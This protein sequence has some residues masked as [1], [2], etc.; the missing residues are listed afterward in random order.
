MS[1][2]PTPI[3]SICR[4]NGTET[5]DSS[6]QIGFP[7]LPEANSRTHFSLIRQWLMDCDQ[8]HA[9]HTTTLRPMPKRVIDVEKG[10]PETVHLYETNGEDQRYVA[11]SHRWGPREN[12]PLFCTYSTNIADFKKTGI[13]VKDLPKTF[14]D[15]VITTRE[16]GIR[17]LWIDSLCIIQGD[18]GDWG[19]Q[20]RCM[21]EVFSSAYCVIAGSRATGTT[22]GFL[23]E[24]LQRKCAMFLRDLDPPIY[25]CDAIDNF[26]LHVIKGALNKRGWVLQERALARRT[27]Y[28]TEKQ[29]YWEC[30]HGVRCETLTK[31]RNTKAS[32]LGD[33]EF[34]KLAIEMSKG[35]K[36]R[37]YETLYK[38]YSRLELTKD[39]D[40]P[41]AIAGLEKRI[42]NALG[43]RGGYGVFEDQEAGSGSYLGRSLLWKRSADVLSMVRITFNPNRVYP[44]PSWSWMA[45]QGAI[46]Y[47]D[48]PFD[49]VDWEKE[50]IRSPWTYIPR[51]SMWLTAD[52]TANTMLT[53]VGRDLSI[54][55][56]DDVVFDEY[57]RKRDLDLKCVV[58]GCSKTGSSID[59]KIHYVLLVGRGSSVENGI[60]ERLGVAKL[61][62]KRITLDGPGVEL[63]IQ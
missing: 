48:L 18:N 49:G 37:L 29:T 33:P 41:L 21:E 13:K 8:N 15:S 61:P 34:P 32:F 28:F 51:K 24:R 35:G 6:I 58:I 53:G 50:E 42:I 2:D 1:G 56:E 30:G 14:E 46:D 11:L 12:H 27:V 10:W 25:V 45:Y 44:V 39:E 31:M 22:D 62:G 5:V 17:Y 40:R 47:M 43:A 38:Q 26:D 55:E 23:K 59:N 57:D 20:A 54:R 9:C 3:F 63:R 60:W 52:R 19:E 4:S 36:I 7:R 16:L